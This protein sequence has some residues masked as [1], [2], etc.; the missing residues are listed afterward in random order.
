MWPDNGNLAYVIDRAYT[1][2]DVNDAYRVAAYAVS[3]DFLPRFGVGSSVMAITPEPLR[4]FYDRFFT[5]AFTGRVVEHRYQ[6][7]TPK[8]YRE[9]ILRALPARDRGSLYLEHGLV[10]D[11]PHEQV[12]PLSVDELLPR[13]RQGGL[14]VQCC[15]C[16]KVRR[17][18]GSGRWDWVP[19]LLRVPGSTIS[20]GI[21]GPCLEYHYP[22]PP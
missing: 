6:C 9:W 5:D 7:H 18:D 14:I 17:S 8:D 15:H 22:D 4:P 2:V 16:R 19:S 10:V 1:I 21:C 3:P 11:H 20:H 12:E 13:Y